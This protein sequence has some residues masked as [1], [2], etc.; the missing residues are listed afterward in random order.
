MTAEFNLLHEPWIVATRRDG[1]FEELSLLG[2]LDRAGD[3]SAIGGELPTQ[4]FALTRLLLAFL[5]RALD[6]PADAEE[7]AELWESPGLPM[8]RITDYARRVEDRFY[9][10]HDELPFMQVAGLR[11]NDGTDRGLQ[12]LLTEVPAGTPLFSRRSRRSV[13]SIGSAEA[14]RWLVNLHAYDIA[15]IKTG[16]VGDP[17]VKF[18]KGY[19]DGAAVCAYIGGILLQGSTVRDTLLLN[20]IGRDLESHVTIGGGDDLPVWERD[21]DT[22]LRNQRQPRGAVQMYAWQSRRVR[23]SGNQDGVT[24]VLV[25]Y[26]D[27]VDHANLHRVEPHTAWRLNATRSRAEK[28]T[29]YSPL[30]HNP[31]RAV[32]QGL[33]ALLPSA[34]R[35]SGKPGQP[36]A[37]LA[38]GVLH[39]AGHLVHEGYLP[40]DYVP[41]LRA[42]GMV[43]NADRTSPQELIDDVLPL[44]LT[45]LGDDPAAAATVLGAADDADQAARTAADLATNVAVASGF[46]GKAD[47]G[48]GPGAREDVYGLLEPQFRA[49]L[50][51]L[52]GAASFEAARARWRETVRAAAWTVADDHTSAVPTT[53]WS[54][55]ETNGRRVNLPLADQWFRNALARALPLP[56]KPADDQDTDDREDLAS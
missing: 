35:N 15:G 6:G 14:A 5:H 7:W 17:L 30:P 49:W 19:A 9:L 42:T 3:F 24:G 13:Q 44:P 34:A 52:P 20:M 51:G 55:V 56:D 50:A 8:D 37:V 25:C 27:R 1:S 48:P 33:A 16:A 11:S 54:G 53:A 18:G 12:L 47:L 32:W 40:E 26:G 21:P 2:L 22:V 23:L 43:Y 10:F 46:R 28:A 38:P 36:A 45:L 31:A 4:T 29:V 39:W 41:T